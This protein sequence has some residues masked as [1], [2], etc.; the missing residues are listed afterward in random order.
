M[1]NKLPT[2]YRFFRSGSGSD[3][4]QSPEQLKYLCGESTASLIDTN[5]SELN[6]INLTKTHLTETQVSV[7]RMGLGFCSSHEIDLMEMIKDLYLFAC[8]LTYKYMFDLKRK[9]KKTE[10]EISKQIKG[11]TMKDF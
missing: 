4:S 2:K 5:S 3:R 8:N 10:R 11:F 6:I 9:V 7:L 1:F